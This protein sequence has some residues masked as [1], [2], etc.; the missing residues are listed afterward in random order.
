MILH[1]LVHRAA[2]GLV[3]SLTLA[4]L[5][6][7]V[8]C[9]GSANALTDP[10]FERQTPADRHGWIPIG[11]NFSPEYARSGKWSMLDAAAFGVSGSFQQLPAAP[12][13]RWRLTGYGFTPVPLRSSPAF[14]IVQ[15]SFFDAAGKDLG[16]LETVGQQFPA[17]TSA[18]LDASS[19]ANTW[20]L[21]DTGSA[22]APPGAAFI[23]AFTLYIDFSGKYQRVFFDDLNLRVLGVTHGAYVASIALNA[24]AL[25]RDGLISEAQQEAMVEAAAESN[26]GKSCAEGD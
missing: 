12:G 6:S 26:A 14:G 18:S 24:N 16:T 10:G 5:A 22:T 17:K 8:P 7:A 4:D 3:L 20:T 1:H 25:R 23:Q 13:S 15:V 19:Q 21:L 2:L 11:G 9:D